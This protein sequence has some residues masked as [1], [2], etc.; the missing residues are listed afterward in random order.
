MQIL[1][2]K[3]SFKI[4]NM[5]T[6]SLLTICLC[7]FGCAISNKNKT[8][9]NILIKLPLI[10]IKSCKVDS[11]I[12]TL[13]RDNQ[14]CS[15]KKCFILVGIK[16]IDKHNNTEIFITFYEKKKFELTCPKN[17]I[18]LVGYSEIDNQTILFVGKVSNLMKETKEQRDF[19]FICRKTGK[20]YPP[21]MYN[22][23]IYKFLYK[24]TESI[25]YKIE[26]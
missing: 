16:E 5:K 13:V 22:P 19:V 26:N 9:D 7:M 23:P 25:I 6:L 21:S 14:Y 3:G 4:M 2:I 10:K 24:N 17:D 1:T 8:G 20:K 12:N 11:L 18:S 15:E